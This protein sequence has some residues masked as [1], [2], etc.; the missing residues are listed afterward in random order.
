MKEKHVLLISVFAAAFF[1][2]IKSYASD[3]E[4]IIFGCYTENPGD[5]EKFVIRAKQSGA[6]HINLSNE[7]LP[8]SY[9]QYDTPGDPYPSWVITN[10]GL[11]KIATP[12]ALKSY[13]PQDYAEKVMKILEERCKILRKYGLKAAIMTFEPQMLPEKV[14]EDHPLWRGARVDHP[15]RSKVVRWAPSID[16]PEVLGL[17]RESVTKLIRRCPEIE[18]LSLTTNDSGTGLDWSAGLYGGKIGNTLYEDRDMD[19]RLVGFFNALMQGAKDAGGDLEIDIQ[20]TREENPE[21]IAVQLTKGMAIENFEG[22]D[23]KLFKAQAGFLL[24]Y[25]NLYYPV[26]GIPYPVR[27][28]NELQ[29][30]WKSGAP[31]LFVLIGDHF[32]RDLY[33]SI[34]D[35]FR[36]NPVQDEIAGLEFLKK[37]ASSIAGDENAEDL[38]KIW[39]DLN[40]IQKLHYFVETGGY[41]FY[42]GCVQQRW[43][44]RPFVPFPE[45]LKP[46]E[47]EYYRKYQFQ[48]RAEEYTNDLMDLQ[49]YRMYSGWTGR[50]ITGKIM[51]WFRNHIQDA[52]Q[53]TRMIISRSTVELKSEFELFDLRLQ[54]FLCVIENANNAVSYQAQLDRIKSLGIVPEKNPVAGSRSSWDRQ[55]IMETA[56]KEIDNTAILI[57]LLKST[58]KVLLYISP[59]PAYDDIRFLEY[60][61]PE[62]LQKKLNIM[63]AHWLDYNRLFT[64]TKY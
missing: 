38:L 10:I 12:E 32:N 40:E 4:K 48:G 22:P 19:E 49:G 60:N 64:I 5:F 23:A 39:L 17:Y 50:Y 30:A 58:D 41:I 34:Y 3:F 62:S 16:N 61:L 47:K 44:T 21:R 35:R 26:A 29:N 6:T 54:V 52:R 57:Q 36:E 11:L 55:L 37:I 2:S 15:V 31:R 20:W 14:F 24:D 42:L 63:N 1:L 28:L 51:E 18:I 13:I 7:D 25:F 8:K 27:F 59:A 9:W 45:E 46:E 53:H 56:R 43:L 33:M